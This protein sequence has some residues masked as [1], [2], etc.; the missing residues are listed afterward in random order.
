MADLLFLRPHG[1]FGANPP[2]HLIIN[3]IVLII[4][5]FAIKTLIF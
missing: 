2:L 4:W 1:H 5:F 3:W